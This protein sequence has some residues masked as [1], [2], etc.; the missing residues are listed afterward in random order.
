MADGQF[1]EL[2]EEVIEEKVEDQNKEEQAVQN[3]QM[4]DTIIQQLVKESMN[5]RRSKIESGQKIHESEGIMLP[6]TEV[7]EKYNKWYPNL[8]LKIPA[9]Y[10]MAINHRESCKFGF[11]NVNPKDNEDERFSYHIMKQI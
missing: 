1:M 11:L 2:Q 5:L 9:N 10:Q 3:K 7:L 4:N 8:F 6:I